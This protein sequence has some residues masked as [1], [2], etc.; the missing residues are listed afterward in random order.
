MVFLFF[1][2]WVCLLL[3]LGPFNCLTN[4]FAMIWFGCCL[5][6][7]LLACCKVLSLHTGSGKGFEPLLATFNALLGV[8]ISFVLATNPMTALVY[9]TLT[10]T[11]YLVVLSSWGW[12][13]LL[14]KDRYK[15]MSL[16]RR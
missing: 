9:P 15:S 5:G 16:V 3:I 13:A 11:V 6:G 12:M 10:T 7:L 8:G 4:G 14:A 1:L 2:P